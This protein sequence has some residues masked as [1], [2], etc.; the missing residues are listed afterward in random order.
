MCSNSPFRGLGG[1][2]PST[3]QHIGQ[4]QNFQSTV[5]V[6]CAAINMHEATHI[7]ADDVFCA[8]GGGIGYF[9][10]AHGDADGFEFHGKGSAETATGFYI[11]HF[12]YFQPFYFAE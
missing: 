3:R 6:F 4:M 1:K 10:I 11:I 7:G 9:L 5:F 8:G 2:L 12:Y